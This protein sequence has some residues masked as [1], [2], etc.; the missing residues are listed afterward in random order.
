MFGAC[1]QG[2]RLFMAGSGMSIRSAGTLGLRM[3]KLLQG[4]PM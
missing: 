4:K 2:L 3:L 1:L